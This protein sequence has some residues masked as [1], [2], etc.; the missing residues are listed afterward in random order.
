MYGIVFFIP[1]VNV[2]A[3]QSESE[4]HFFLSQEKYFLYTWKEK[5][6]HVFFS[7]TG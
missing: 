1:S 2:L 6:I 4:K 3:S 5:L 7:Q